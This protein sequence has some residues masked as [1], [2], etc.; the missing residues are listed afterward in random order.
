ME[1]GLIIMT[2]L[3]NAMSVQQEMDVLYGA[4][5]SAT[6]GRGEVVLMERRGATARNANA[7]VL[8]AAA[9]GSILSFGFEDFLAV[10][11]NERTDD[12]ISK[13]PFDKCFTEEKILQAWRKVGF[14]PFTRNC[15]SSK[16][17]RHKLGQSSA[18][19]AL[20]DLQD[21]FD[22]IMSAVEVGG[23]LNEG[24]LDV[25]IPV[26]RPLRRIN[27]DDGQVQQLLAQTGAF[28]T[29]ALWSTCGTRIG[30]ARVALRA[31]KEEIALNDAKITKQSRGR[32]DRQAK[33]LQMHRRH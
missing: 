23:L 26:A 13:R 12:D 19:V 29:S 10:I 25:T 20:E 5:K 31:Q 33:L 3:P 14:V 22:S 27:D 28:S 30:N 24:I 9:G 6:Y 21:H 8:V 32:L 11:V 18:N 15:L 16:K 1:M 4:F 7:R 17:V 2:G